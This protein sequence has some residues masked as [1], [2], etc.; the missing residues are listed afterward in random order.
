[1]KKPL[2]PVTDHAVI[3]Y[4]ERVEGMDIEV[5]RRQIGRT[6]DEAVRRGAAGTVA[7]GFCYKIKDGTV[8]TIWEQNLPDKRTHRGR[9]KGGK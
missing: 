1:M 3:R 9:P 8:V 5:I 6:V 2:H 4:L 7:G